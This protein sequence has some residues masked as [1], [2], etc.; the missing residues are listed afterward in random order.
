MK[1]RDLIKCAGYKP[2]PIAMDFAM[3][4]DD[5]SD[6]LIPCQSTEESTNETFYTN[7]GLLPPSIGE[8]VCMGKTT[9]LEL[10]ETNLDDDEI[11]EVLSYLLKLQDEYFGQSLPLADELCQKF[12]WN[13]PR[14]VYKLFKDS[15][16]YD[17]PD[18]L[19]IMTLFYAFC[20]KDLTRTGMCKFI[21]KLCSM[22]H[23]A[24]TMFN[25]E[26][27]I[28]YDEYIDESDNDIIPDDHLVEST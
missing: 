11:T 17:T 19:N 15:I 25:I 5:G 14:E 13:M 2:T 12:V 8:P 22:F 6:F 3:D 7:H 24:D 27:M 9:L 28:F 10:E 23:I 20:M 18:A 4:F 1:V 26:D 21:D 16:D